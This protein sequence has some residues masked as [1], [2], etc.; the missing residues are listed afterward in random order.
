MT[1]EAILQ[2][3]REEVER[4][5]L[6]PE[7]GPGDS[8]VVVLDEATPYVRIY[9]DRESWSGLRM[10]ALARMRRLPNEA[11]HEAFWAEFQDENGLGKCPDCFTNMVRVKPRTGGR[12]LAMCPRCHP[13]TVQEGAP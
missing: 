7:A 1:I 11:G 12:P 6:G 8:V 2:T 4:L 13:V 9:D 10:V 3:F 5:G